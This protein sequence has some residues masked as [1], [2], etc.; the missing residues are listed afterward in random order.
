LLPVS[1]GGNHIGHAAFFCG[2]I[3]KF[4]VG[5]SKFA[6]FSDAEASAMKNTTRSACTHRM[7]NIEILMDE[8]LTDYA[9][10]V[11]EA[12][13]LGRN[14]GHTARDPVLAEVL[15]KLEAH[16]NAMRFLNAMGRIAWKAT[17]NLRQYLKDLELDAQ[18]DLRDI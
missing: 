18:E 14:D 6:N 17:P 9:E 3:G 5:G 10:E 11:C 2:G 13:R 12:A 8:I 4:R 15:A 7:A 1:N 16:G